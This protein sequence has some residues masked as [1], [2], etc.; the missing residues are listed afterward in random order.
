MSENSIFDVLSKLLRKNVRK[1]FGCA[2]RKEG[3]NLSVI[4][5]Y[6]TIN[7]DSI[8]IINKEVKNVLLT[9]HFDEIKYVSVMMKQIGIYSNNNKISKVIIQETNEF[10]KFIQLEYSKYFSLHEGTSKAI[11]IISEDK[12][13]QCKDNLR[14][15]W[16]N[17]PLMHVPPEFFKLIKFNNNIFF[18]VPPSFKIIATNS[19]TL[20]HNNHNN[21]I[22]P[23][24]H[25]DFFL[26]Q[27]KQIM[28][29]F[30]SLRKFS[31]SFMKSYFET[32]FKNECH[33][34][35]KQE[36]PYH[37]K[38]NFNEDEC[39]IQGYYL[40]FTIDG[41]IKKEYLCYIIR[42][43]YEPPFLE[44]FSDFVFI[45]HCEYQNE[46]TQQFQ[47]DQKTRNEIE[48]IVDSLYEEN[49]PNYNE[50]TSLIELNIIYL[51]YNYF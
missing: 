26:Q 27:H 11:K 42:K 28:N 51:N 44:T 39:L 7:E 17:L 1:I 36:H 48:L 41:P 37:K 4:W 6:L 16:K 18:F 25:F 22:N 20:K 35:I 13:N 49:I 9:I 43:L 14:N 10:V 12:V 2:L 3:F 15:L 5:G 34:T 50:Y 32:N 8:V 23:L 40:Q 30:I 45:F 33:Y 47:L 19:G 31:K 38:Y 21:I 29:D 46:M 24:I